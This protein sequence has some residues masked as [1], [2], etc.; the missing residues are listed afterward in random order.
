MSASAC[1]FEARPSLW[2]STVRSQLRVRDL[3]DQEAIAPWLGSQRGKAWLPGGGRLLGASGAPS[4]WPLYHRA[5]KSLSLLW[6]SVSRT[7]L[8]APECYSGAHTPGHAVRLPP[9]VL[10]SAPTTLAS[11][12]GG[13]GLDMLC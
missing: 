4:H 8:E 7:G 5:V 6:V 9:H 12:Q 1:R 3:T 13:K 2:C 10:S 11:G